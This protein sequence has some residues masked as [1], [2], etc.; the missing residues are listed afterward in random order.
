MGCTHCAD[1]AAGQGSSSQGPT[2]QNQNA[3]EQG[4]QPNLNNMY[5]LNQLSDYREGDPILSM[6]IE[7]MSQMLNDPI[8][9]QYFDPVGKTSGPSG[10]SGRNHQQ[11]G[12]TEYN[13]QRS[14]YQNQQVFI[15]PR[16][17]YRNQPQDNYLPNQ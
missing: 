9:L 17:N 5:N 3:S 12:F 14:S 2:Q 1:G 7:D 6:S 11:T 4:Y 13:R 16:D 15:I 10:G 8:H